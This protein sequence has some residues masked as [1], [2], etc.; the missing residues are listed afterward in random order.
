MAWWILTIL[1]LYPWLQNGHSGNLQY[2]NVIN[3]SGIHLGTNFLFYFPLHIGLANNASC[4]FVVYSGQQATKYYSIIFH[5]SCSLSFS[6]I[7]VHS[8][9]VRRFI[10]FPFFC[11]YNLLLLLLLFKL[12]ELCSLSLSP[13]Y[14]TSI[15][16]LSTN[17]CSTVIIMQLLYKMGSINSPWLTCLGKVVRSIFFFLKNLPTLFQVT[18][19]DVV[20][21]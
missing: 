2:S 21:K 3:L 17:I 6:V 18:Q 13:P 5:L 16:F 8:F 20:S 11:C 9:Q 14:C 10:N 19:K 12:L 4:C 1:E 15:Y 7:I